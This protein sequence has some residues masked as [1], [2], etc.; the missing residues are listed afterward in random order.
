MVRTALRFALLVTLATVV[1]TIPV[2]AQSNGKPAII[3]AY[4][5]ADY[6][7]LFVEGENF[8]SPTVVLGETVLTG[9]AVDPT[10]RYLS[11]VLPTL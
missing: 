11:A 5:S 7:T 6:T 8:N 1:S 4:V 9:I 3:S 2:A 10:K